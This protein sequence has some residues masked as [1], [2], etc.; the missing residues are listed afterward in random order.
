[1]RRKNSIPLFITTTVRKP[2]NLKREKKHPSLVLKKM[3]VYLLF[4]ERYLLN[5]NLKK[6]NTMPDL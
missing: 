2:K 5:L 6:Y 3:E 4:I 1:V